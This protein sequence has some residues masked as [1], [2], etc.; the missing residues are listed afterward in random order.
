MLLLCHINIVVI[1]RF[2]QNQQPKKFSRT[3]ISIYRAHQILNNCTMSHIRYI[4][5]CSVTFSVCIMISMLNV[6]IGFH[7]IVGKPILFAVLA[8]CCVA[9]VMTGICMQFSTDLTN[10][11]K[12]FVAS[13]LRNNLKIGKVTRK[14]LI[15][16]KALYVEIGRIGRIKETTF[17]NIISNIVVSNVINLLLMH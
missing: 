10:A 5:L 7:R 15:A 4:V 16:S 14:R 6:A 8:T 2:N 1:Y 12:Q 3:L 17:P 9:F 11:S 13:H